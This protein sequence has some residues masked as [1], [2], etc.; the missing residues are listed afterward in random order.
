MEEGDRW[1]VSRKFEDKDSSGQY[2]ADAM[3]TWGEHARGWWRNA[4]QYYEGRS[5]NI[6]SRV[7][8]GQGIQETG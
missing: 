7:G 5:S 6:I 1:D 4:Y 2:P 3:T 8:V